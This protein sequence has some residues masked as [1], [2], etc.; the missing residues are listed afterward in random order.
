MSSLKEL[1]I[2]KGYTQQDVADF[3]EISHQAYSYYEMNKRNMNV[4]T[5]KKLADFFKVPISMITGNSDPF[6]NI[7]K[8]V[9]IK[10]PVVRNYFCRITYISHREY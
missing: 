9:G 10:V 5:A 2:A 3:L 1:R 7:I 8:E 4:D 6:S